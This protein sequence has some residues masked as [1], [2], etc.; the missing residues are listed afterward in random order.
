M[1][2]SARIPT[3]R[4][5]AG[6]RATART[7]QRASSRPRLASR[8]GT[9]ATKHAAAQQ[10]FSRSLCTRILYGRVQLRQGL[11][12]RTEE[13]AATSSRLASEI[14]TSEDIRVGTCRGLVELNSR[15]QACDVLRH[16]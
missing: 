10:L 13:L 7:R 9:E 5:S 8:Q 1:D 3:R 4:C 15:P 12:A 16:M 14:A 11:E 2:C 6:A